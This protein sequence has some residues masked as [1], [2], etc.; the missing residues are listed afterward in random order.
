[1]NNLMRGILG[2]LLLVI[3]IFSLL[4]IVVISIGIEKVNMRDCA[5]AGGKYLLSST[6][7]LRKDAIIWQRQP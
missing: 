7:C 3:A 6:L 2:F 5:K 1:M 4:E